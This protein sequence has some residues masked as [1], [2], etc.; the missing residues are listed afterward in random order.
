MTN[1]GNRKRNFVFSPQNQ[2]NSN[3]IKISLPS[4]LP[5]WLKFKLSGRCRNFKQSSGCSHSAPIPPSTRHIF[6]FKHNRTALYSFLARGMQI[7]CFIY[8]AIQI[9][10]GSVGNFYFQSLKTFKMRLKSVINESHKANYGNAQ[11]EIM[12]LYGEGVEI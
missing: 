2:E 4:A 3:S 9:S 6:I 8:R 7:M 11:S 5:C 10:F 1:Y 12:S